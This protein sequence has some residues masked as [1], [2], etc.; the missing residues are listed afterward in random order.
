M[1]D[2]YPAMK[3][4]IGSTS[5]YMLSMKANDVANMLKIPKEMPGWDE[6]AITER[7]QRDIDY[8][9]VKKHIAP[10][11]ANDPDRF[12]GSLI[13]T[14]I[15]PNYQ[16]EEMMNFAGQNLPQLYVNAAKSFGFLNFTGAEILVP[17]DGQH[18][19]SA[20]QMALTA[21]DEKSKILEGFEPN[22]ELAKDDILIILL[23]HDPKKSRKI[24]N[25]VN[26]YAKPTN[27]AT[28][29]ITADDDVIANI[30]RDEICE[31]IGT[32]LINLKG[33][34]LS[35]KAG[36]FTTL[37]TIYDSTREILETVFGSSI[38]TTELPDTQLIKQYSKVAQKYWNEVTTKVDKFSAALLDKEE[39]GDDTRR[40][41]RA[42]FLLGKP[43][44]QQALM[45]AIIRLSQGQTASG[46]K[47][48]FD[49]IMT[50]VN[51]VD[52]KKENN[53][54][55]NILM[56]GSRIATGKQATAFA[57][58][59]IAYYLGD[60]VPADALASLKEQYKRSFSDDEFTR[61]KFPGRKYQ[62]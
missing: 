22:T 18:R 38:S 62:P 13:V 47:L 12:F 8:N 31:I 44:A 57:G 42:K 51:S 23:D 46:G 24:F 45:S 26:R 49:E 7:Y 1:P 6:M 52:W 21:K 50:R 39:S 9:R 48:S 54:W 29:L 4:K 41:I 58:K 11:L 34:T 43:I 15:N 55:Q 35:D 19:L 60:N 56:N 28:N 61:V 20:L 32:R 5:Y 37:S 30:A 16:W 3:G 14:V 2:L 17:L 36:E 59:F 27:K 25:K 53:M 10:Y 33:S 40:D